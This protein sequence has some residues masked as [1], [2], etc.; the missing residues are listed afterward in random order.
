[1]RRRF[2]AVAVLLLSIAAAGVSAPN[3]PIPSS[4]PGW[5]IQL[6]SPF[7]GAGAA[8]LFMRRKQGAETTLADRAALESSAK[9][10]A[11]L[12]E[13]VA[14]LQ[15]SL[16]AA[17]DEVQELRDEVERLRNALK[18]VEPADGAPIKPPPPRLPISRETRRGR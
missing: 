2:A 18:G 6:V 5:L 16:A 8:W 14:D 4:A 13:Q 17:H 15:E 7:L 1:M 9:T 12:F 11:N 10:I 3:G